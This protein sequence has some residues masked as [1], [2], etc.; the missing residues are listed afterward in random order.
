NRGNSRLDIAAC[1]SP[2]IFPPW[3]SVYDLYKPFRNYMRRF[4]FADSMKKIWILGGHLA[5]Q[6]PQGGQLRFPDEQGWPDTL[7]GTT[8]PW[9]LELL[10]RETILNSPIMGGD[11]S[12]GRWEDFARAINFIRDID[13]EISKRI[14]GEEILREIH[15]IVH[16]QFPW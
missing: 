7:R 12:L 8:F 2:L 3:N 13:N 1:W 16:R 6:G 14:G 15:R 5:G 10:A 4:P 11:K 9:D